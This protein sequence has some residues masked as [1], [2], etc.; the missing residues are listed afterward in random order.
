MTQWCTN[1]LV[2]AG[3]RPELDAAINLLRGDLPESEQA[4][5]SLQRSLF[6]EIA[7]VPQDAGDPSCPLVFD[8]LLPIPPEH[9][10]DRARDWCRT[11]WGTESCPDREGILAIPRMSLDIMEYIFRTENRAPVEWVRYFSAMFP[12]FGI[13]LHSHAPSPKDFRSWTFREGRILRETKYDNSKLRRLFLIRHFGGMRP[14]TY[15]SQSGSDDHDL[16]DFEQPLG[17]IGRETIDLLVRISTPEILS[18]LQERLRSKGLTAEGAY[19]LIARYVKEIP[20]EIL[21]EILKYPV[22]THAFALRQSISYDLA[23]LAVRS[24]LRHLLDERIPDLP[25]FFENALT[26]SAIP[27]PTG[28]D[29]TSSQMAPEKR[30]EAP[31]AMEMSEVHRSWAERIYALRQVLSRCIRF[32]GLRL[33]ETECEALVQR[34]RSLDPQKEFDRLVRNALIEVLARSSSTP[35]HV[36]KEICPKEMS[37]IVDL[38]ATHPNIST[39]YCAELCK[40]PLGVLAQA[41]IALGCHVTKD[42]AVIRN[43][44]TPENGSSSAYHLPLHPFV[45]WA[46]VLRAP[47]SE[48]GFVWET[49]A[50]SDAITA[51]P[52][53]VLSMLETL[54]VRCLIHAPQRLWAQLLCA[55]DRDLRE[56]TLRLISS[57]SNLQSDKANQSPDFHTNPGLQPKTR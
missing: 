43:L 56:R 8:R 30:V 38:I 3:C 36:L 40:F 34:V 53:I 48:L 9:I 24:A 6:P 13:A 26:D 19:T 22:A 17:Q 28:H 35:E 1:R 18:E 52:G 57:V 45:F 29:A 47:T 41:T 25:L 2:I 32:H 20:D 42:P 49:L 37:G 15:V 55:E 27:S 5:A 31:Q 51:H 12:S 50:N 44:L 33:C 23:N 14:S 7:V 16:F 21:N 54:P 39:P 46:I 10:P 4:I 11:H